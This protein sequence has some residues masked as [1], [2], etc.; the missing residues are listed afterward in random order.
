[1]GVTRCSFLG[2][3]SFHQSF[4]GMHIPDVAAFLQVVKSFLAKGRPSGAPRRPSLASH[5]HSR[6]PRLAP[7]LQHSMVASPHRRKARALE[8]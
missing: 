6:A 5:G 4:L 7:R 3:Q 2:T 8:P 1:M